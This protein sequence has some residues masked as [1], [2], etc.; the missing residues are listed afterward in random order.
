MIITVR[1]SVDTAADRFEPENALEL[2]IEKTMKIGR[3]PPAQGYFGIST[4]RKMVFPALLRYE[5]PGDFGNIGKGLEKVFPD[6]LGF[7]YHTDVKLPALKE[8][9]VVRGNL[10]SPQNNPTGWQLMLDLLCQEETS[11]HI[12][13]V[14]THSDDVWFGIQNRFEDSPITS[15]AHHLSRQNYHIN[16]LLH[17]DRLKIRRSKRDVFIAEEEIVGLDGKL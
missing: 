9:T 17:C 5:K 14:A 15:V 7:A 4:P 6:L 10:G 3:R 11:L 1:A 16:T 2:A 13:Q 12:P 8:K